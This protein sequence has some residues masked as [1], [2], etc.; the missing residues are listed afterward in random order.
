MFSAS[1]SLDPGHRAP[2]YDARLNVFGNRLATCSGDQLVKIF[3]VRENS[4]LQLAEL[5]GHQGPVW[6]V[7]WAHPRFGT[8]CASAGYDSRVIFWQEKET[9]WEKL[10]EYS[11]HSGS[12]NTLSFAS[13]RFGLKLACGSNDGSISIHSY[14]HVNGRWEAVKIENAHSQGITSISWAPAV[15]VDEEQKIFEPRFITCGNDTF[16]KIWAFREN[17]WELEKVL[18][19]HTDFVRDVAW[20]PIVYDG[21]HKILSVG[22]DRQVLLWRSKAIGKEEWGFE[23]ITKTEGAI[24]HACWSPCAT[25]FTI[26]GEDNKNTFFREYGNNWVEIKEENEGNGEAETNA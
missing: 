18:V 2:I 13:E 25:L 16:L 21:L 4:L 23:Q 9:G 12:V 14:D 11:E 15:P 10:Y 22:Q 8:L 19:A 6:Q 1:L 3:E 17:S 20:C 26:S 5:G 7:D 24:W